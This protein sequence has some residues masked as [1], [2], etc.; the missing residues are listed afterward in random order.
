[1]AQPPR[2][3]PVAGCSRRDATTTDVAVVAGSHRIVR[4]ALIIVSVLAAVTMLL[5][6]I[7]VAY[8]CKKNRKPHK[9]V[10]IASDGH[11]D[12]GEMRSSESLMYDLSTLPAATDN[13][14]EE[15]KLEEGWYFTKWAGDCSEE[16][17]QN[18]AARACGDEGPI[19]S[20][21]DPHL[22]PSMAS[23]VVM[24]NSRSITLPVPAEP[25]FV[26]PDQRPRV[27][28]PEPSINEDSVSDL[29]PR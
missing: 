27:A 24:L 18:F 22:R 11:G 6:L 25:A 15:N 3:V 23:I 12:E 9:H 16:T 17:V 20:Q 1:M 29:E 7:V 13:F 28:A 21:E 2:V 4:T 19:W 5:L 14:S 26:T 8:T 10:Q